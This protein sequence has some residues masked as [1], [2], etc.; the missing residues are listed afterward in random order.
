MS[1]QVEAAVPAAVSE[2]QGSYEAWRTTGVVPEAAP[3]AEEKKEESAEADDEPEGK[4]A[5]EG[6]AEKPKKL[7]GFQRKLMA[8]DEQLLEAHRQIAELK[9]MIPK[10]EQPAGPPEEPAWDYNISDVDNQARI[11]QW[12]KDSAQW[13]VQQAQQKA[14]QEAAERAAAEKLSKSMEEISKKY[15]DFRDKMRASEKVPVSADMRAYLQEEAENQGE[16]VYWLASNPVEAARIATM[17]PTKAMAALA[18][19]DAK[20]G[21]DATERKAPPPATGS[22][23]P[24]PIAPVKSTS[25]S[26]TDKPPSEMTQ[27][28]YEAWRAKT[29]RK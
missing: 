16:M 15:P 17:S 19:I 23:L 14:A 7:G 10:P 2:D 13:E 18:R 21:S 25:A 1:E 12:A 26:A 28:E 9:A 24:P 6:A 8:K 22:P 4:E 29:G 3:P 27:A 20:L 11:R 5:A